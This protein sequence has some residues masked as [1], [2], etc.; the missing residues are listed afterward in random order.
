[1]KGLNIGSDSSGVT[2]NAFA[3]SS[4]PCFLTF[5]FFCRVLAKSILARR[6]RTANLVCKPV[7]E[8]KRAEIFLLVLHF[9]N[10]QSDF[11]TSLPQVQGLNRDRSK[12]QFCSRFLEQTALQALELVSQLKIKESLRIRDFDAV[13]RPFSGM[14]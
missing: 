11:T 1:M 12:T 14:F 4:Y 13:G 5:Q 3:A 9:A 6:R 2:P 7:R 8:W 10:Q